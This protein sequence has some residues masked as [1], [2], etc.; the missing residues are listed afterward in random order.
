MNPAAPEKQGLANLFAANLGDGVKVGF[1]DMKNSR[2]ARVYESQNWY[3][4]RPIPDNPSLKLFCESFDIVMVPGQD[5]A[6]FKA[7]LLYLDRIDL[8]K[9]KAVCQQVVYY[10][11]HILHI[12]SMPARGICVEWGMP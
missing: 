6:G 9:F 4:N 12:Y 2:L 11:W 1:F 5:K 7:T 8:N 3:S 10:D